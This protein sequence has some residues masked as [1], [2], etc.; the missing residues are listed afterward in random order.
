MWLTAAA[1]AD[2]TVLNLCYMMCHCPLPSP[3]Y[4]GSESLLEAVAATA[5]ELKKA[6]PNVTYG[7]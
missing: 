6:N 5:V 3:G 7:E 2:A 4:I 1:T